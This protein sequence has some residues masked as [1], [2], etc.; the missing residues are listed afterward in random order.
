MA[1]QQYAADRIRVNT[2]IP[3]LIDTPRVAKNVARM[4]DADARA[5][6]AARDRQV[7]MGRM[8]TP[9]EVANAVAFLASD[10]AS[11]ITGTELV[12]DGGLTGKYA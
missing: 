8:G 3:G 2:V 5:A 9:W 10:E 6:S 12:V 1:A 11:Y 7:P 4:F